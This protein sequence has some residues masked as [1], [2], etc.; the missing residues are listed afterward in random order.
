[1]L[2]GKLTLFWLRELRA[3]GFEKLFIV[4]KAA[5]WGFTYLKIKKAPAVDRV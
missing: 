3:S 5:V 2:S 1:L 4:C